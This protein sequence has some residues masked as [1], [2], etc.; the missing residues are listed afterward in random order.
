MLIFFWKTSGI[1]SKFADKP[2]IRQTKKVRLRYYVE[3]NNKYNICVSF[4][5]LKKLVVSAIFTMIMNQIHGNLKTLK[6]FG[7]SKRYHP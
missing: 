3:C 4:E 7:N 5:I 2:W 6:A 1:Y